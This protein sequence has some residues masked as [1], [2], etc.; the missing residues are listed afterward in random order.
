MTQD[1]E[2]ILEAVKS[3][4]LALEHA[5]DSLKAD[6]EVVLEAVKSVGGALEYADDSLKGD[7]ELR[8]LATE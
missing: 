3:T 7:P 6:R 1:R 5:D 4:G 8:K 2:K